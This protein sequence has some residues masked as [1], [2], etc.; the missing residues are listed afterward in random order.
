MKHT[1]L[2]VLTI[3]L[4]AA[5]CAGVYD[6][7]IF[8][9]RGGRDL[10][11]NGLC[12]KGEFYDEMHAGNTSHG[13]HQ[14][15]FTGYPESIVLRNEDVKFPCG[16]DTAK[17]MPVLHLKLDRKISA[18]GTVTNTFIP[19]ACPKFLYGQISNQ[20][21]M[22]ARIRRDAQN[23]GTTK[24]YFSRFGYGNGVLYGFTSESGVSATT[25]YA[26]CVT[27][28]YPI[29][30][31]PKSD[32]ESGVNEWRVTNQMINTN[33]WTDISL[34]VSGAIMRVGMARPGTRFGKNSILFDQK[35][36]AA[37]VK[38]AKSS[39]ANDNWRFFTETGPTAEGNITNSTARLGTFSGSVQQIAIWNRALTDDEIR[40]AWGW[41][42][43]SL[44]K[45]GLDNDAGNEFGSTAAPATQT[46]DPYGPW[47]DLAPNLPPGG[48]W[49]VPFK[50]E[51]VEAGLGQLLY[52]SGASSSVA[53]SL[54]VAV[55]GTDLGKQTVT[56]GKRTRWY[57]PG[58]LLKSGNNQLTI[59]APAN[60]TGHIVIDSFELGGS[61]QI[62]QKGV[63]WNDL[64]S[65]G[66]VDAVL[67]TRDIARLHW[68][69]A[70]NLGSSVTSRTYRVWI[71]D[72]VARRHPANFA[73]AC[74]IYQKPTTVTA[75][76]MDVYLNGV[77]H[78]VMTNGVREA[79]IGS[80]KNGHVLWSVPFEPGELKAGWNDITFSAG[81]LKDSANPYF[82]FDYYRFT[83]DR[84]RDGTLMIVR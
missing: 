56:P 43:A 67:T 35:T 29:L 14:T 53:G 39:S 32:T 26:R 40:E 84:S 15:T 52:V 28:M 80:R 16:R 30:Y 27:N 73:L 1:L 4:T 38:L 6:D 62:G 20:Y 10:N 68:P 36:C 49:T 9:F 21:T 37:P 77:Q 7:A 51:A 74:S 71:P 23:F 17:S 13:N 78:D 50:G 5:V 82:M 63:D 42:N 58:N 31:Y 41:P 2:T 79:R 3:G 60:N 65:E 33:T 34:T 72:E 55:N 81:P 66:Y 83:I 24:Q 18:D 64:S 54:A 70:I 19:H 11:G 25:D 8:W 45:V 47:H 69:Q 57:V 75:C 44:L 22:V 46:I 61:W 48:T 12:E 76:Y 59:S